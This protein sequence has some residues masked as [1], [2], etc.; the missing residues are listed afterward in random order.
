MA[1]SVSLAEIIAVAARSAGSYERLAA[2]LGVDE[3]FLHECAAGTKR[4]PF[5][6][7]VRIAE[8]AG[9]RGSGNPPNGRASEATAVSRKSARR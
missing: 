8:F 7:A 3:A 1:T 4:A 5:A 2:A 6:L 9:R